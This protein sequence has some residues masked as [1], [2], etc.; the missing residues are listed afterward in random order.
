MVILFFQDSSLE[1]FN[2]IFIAAVVVIRYA[3]G[4]M[5]I[6]VPVP[7]GSDLIF[8][9]YSLC[10]ISD[11]PV[12]MPQISKNRQNGR[13]IR[14]LQVGSLSIPWPGT[15]IEAGLMGLRWL[16]CGTLGPLKKLIVPSCFS[17]APSAALLRAVNIPI[18]PTRSALYTGRNPAQYWVDYL[19]PRSL[20]GWLKPGGCERHKKTFDALFKKREGCPKENLSILAARR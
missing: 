6:R 5:I 20:C 4:K 7:E 2:R 15:F 8:T 14:F 19:F 9:K 17:F 16:L 12:Q 13:I 3:K 11:L 10:D 18:F 1:L